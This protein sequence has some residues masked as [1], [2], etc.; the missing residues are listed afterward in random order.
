MNIDQG[1][2]SLVTLPAI[3]FDDRFFTMLKNVTE[4]QKHLIGL[5]REKRF[6]SEF[7]APKSLEVNNVD[8]TI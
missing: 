6:D 2:A 5:K 4:D 8:T 3:V 1:S 7:P